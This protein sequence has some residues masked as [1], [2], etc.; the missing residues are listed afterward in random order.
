MKL[1]RLAADKRAL[2]SVCCRPGHAESI[3]FPRIIITGDKPAY[4]LVTLRR[5]RTW[6]FRT[7]LRPFL[8]FVETIFSKRGDNIAFPSAYI[9]LIIN[10]AER[11]PLGYSA[12]ITRCNAL[13]LFI[14][15]ATRPPLLRTRWEQGEREGGEEGGRR[16][17]EN[18]LL[19]E[20][21]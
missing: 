15:N 12:K 5:V 2:S 11:T 14:E 10:F 1:G 17:A 16:E 19:V 9:R 6:T 8:R 21:I 4:P 3:D 20:S 7:R 13:L 18:S